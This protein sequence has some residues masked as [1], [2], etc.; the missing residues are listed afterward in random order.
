[1][2]IP[3]PYAD[4]QGGLHTIAAEQLGSNIAFDSVPNIG[5]APVSSGNPMPVADNAAETALGTPADSAWSSGSGSVIAVLKGIAGKFGSFVLGAGSALIGGVNL[6]DAGGA[7]K[8]GI[9]AAGRVSVDPSGV[10]SPVSIS[11]LVTTTDAANGPVSAGTAATKS[12]LIGGVFNAS[13]PVLA[14]GQQVALQLDGNGRLLANIATGAVTPAPTNAP[15]VYAAATVGTTASTLLAANTAKVFLDIVN[16]S[17]TA[18]LW[19]SV[20]GTAVA[21]AAG[22]IP[23]P[24]GW[25]RSWEGSYVPSDAISCIA[26]AAA[27]SVTIGA[28]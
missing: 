5:G 16:V 11:G 4:Q 23:L 19:V 25:H 9:S 22:T 14:T 28:K 21:G 17:P 24:P 18:T 7:N 27:T 10:T 26:S 12:E 1:M 8:A 13:P 15:G 2:T 20:G 3:I 6:V